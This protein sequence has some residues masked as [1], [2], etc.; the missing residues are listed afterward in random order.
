MAEDGDYQS[1]RYEVDGR[2]ANTVLDRPERLNAIDMHMPGEIR[3]AV[4]TANDDPGVHVIV[5]SGS[6][7]AFCAGYDLKQFAEQSAG[8]QRSPVWDP[9][10]DY[11][12]MRGNTDDFFTLW[13]S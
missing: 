7:R 13:R 4:E 3:R 11:R 1:L 10:K 9:I 5:L 8:H 2:R 6:G 12:G